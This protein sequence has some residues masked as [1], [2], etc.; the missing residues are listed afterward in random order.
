[1]NTKLNLL[2]LKEIDIRSRIWMPCECIYKTFLQEHRCEI[3]AGRYFR[4][5]LALFVQ[6]IIVYV[7]YKGNG[8]GKLLCRIIY[9]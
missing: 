8:R 5:F 9:E 4:Y 7:R 1:M 3:P 2:L 6:K